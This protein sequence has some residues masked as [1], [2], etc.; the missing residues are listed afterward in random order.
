V[1]Q[2]GGDQS[3]N[4]QA[5]RDVVVGGVSYADARQIALD[6][7][8]ANAVQLEATAKQVAIQRAEEMTDKFLGELKARNPEAVSQASRP[9]FQMSLLDA[10]KAYARTG[11][12]EL[13]T[14]LVD[15]LVIRT[16][17]EPRSLRELVLAE[18][19]QVVPRLTVA[20]I[21]TVSAIFLLRY[22]QS[23]G[24]VNVEQLKGWFERYMT[25]LLPSLSKSA[26]VALHLEYSGTATVQLAGA[27]IGALLKGNYAGLFTKGFDEQSVSEL[28]EKYPGLKELLVVAPTAGRKMLP[29]VTKPVLD[30]LLVRVGVADEAVR[31][32][33]WTHQSSDMLN[34]AEAL[35]KI[36]EVCPKFGELAAVW[37]QSDLR[38][39]TLT[40]VGIA[41][42]HANF[43]RLSCDS[44]PLSI[45]IPD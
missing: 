35:A 17:Q 36:V 34:D 12:K 38:R 29:P 39:M 43:Q 3:V 23:R 26:S 27:G 4:V 10:Q 45:W 14:V 41:I 33:L 31:E 9:D 21:N 44:A 20:Q 7:Y 37:D 19:L 8:K 11:D 2:E 13:A 6:V 24:V 22:T 16:Q 5:G 28:L 15:L 40:S 30:S 1:K 32:R 25:P 42:G 18:S